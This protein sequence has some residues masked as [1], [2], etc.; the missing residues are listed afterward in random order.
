MINLTLDVEASIEA[1]TGW[2]DLSDRTAGFELASDSF[3]EKSFGHRK[4]D[5]DSEWIEGTFTSRSVKENTTEKVSVYVVADTPY[6]LAEKVKRVTDAFDQLSFG[7][8]V[9]F[10]DCQETWDCQTSEYTLNTRQEM[11]FATMALINATVPRL[12]TCLRARIVTV[13]GSVASASSRALSGTV[14]IS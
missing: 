3:S 6:E 11:R 13:G 2:I 7:M 8:V 5:V 9:R 14:V 4:T 1:P 12:P 10:A